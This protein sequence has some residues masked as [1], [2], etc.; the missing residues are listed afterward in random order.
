MA[1]TR[2]ESML[3]RKSDPEWNQRQ[4][5][6]GFAPKLASAAR[7]LAAIFICTYVPLVLHAQD[8]C[9]AAILAPAVPPAPPPPSSCLSPKPA[10]NIADGTKSAL[11]CAWIDTPPGHDGTD[12]LLE[13]L[14]LLTSGPLPPNVDEKVLDEL[15]KASARSDDLF[16]AAYFVGWLQARLF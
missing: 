16:S 1:L 8:P 9:D 5:T 3:S 13:A 7:T 14:R 11:A 2:E 12:H 4:G 10:D 15:H 6:T